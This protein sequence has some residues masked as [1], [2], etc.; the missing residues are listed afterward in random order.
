M[1]ISADEALAML[2]K[3][4]PSGHVNG[5]QKAFLDEFAIYIKNRR[6]DGD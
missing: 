6:G 3:K 1:K 2:K 5:V 4:R